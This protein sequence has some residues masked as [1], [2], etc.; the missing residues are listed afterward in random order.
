[1]IKHISP[2]YPPNVLEQALT[3]YQGWK[4]FEEQLTV[5]NFSVKDLEREIEN[6]KKK[7]KLATEVRQKRSQAIEA[8]NKALTDLWKLTKRIR[9]S[10]KATFGDNS[11]E[12]DKFGG[13][14]VR[15]RKIDRE[16]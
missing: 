7:I 3:V 1:M 5:P 16:E 4:E 15:F 8:R 13:K 9:N 6:T 14:S 10:A 12:I 11:K 2:N